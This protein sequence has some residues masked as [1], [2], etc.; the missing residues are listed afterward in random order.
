VK[1]EGWLRVLDPAMLDANAA[2][3]L[4]KGLGWIL[5]LESHVGGALPELEWVVVPGEVP[6]PYDG[7]A[8][9][10]PPIDV[11]VFTDTVQVRVVDLATQ[12]QYLRAWAARSD[13]YADDARLASDARRMRKQATRA[14]TRADEVDAVLDLL[15]SDWATGAAAPGQALPIRSLKLRR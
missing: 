14:R 2:A 11:P 12:V 3:D 8:A 4:E 7:V 6:W 10:W 5:R 1:S 15:P 13:Q 9:G